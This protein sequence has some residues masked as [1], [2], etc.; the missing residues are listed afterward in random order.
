MNGRWLDALEQYISSC[1]N[2]LLS[3]VYDGF[4]LTKDITICSTLEHASDII[5]GYHESRTWSDPAPVMYV[6]TPAIEAH[7]NSMSGGVPIADFTA[8]N[9]PS[10]YKIGRAHV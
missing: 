2:D 5:H 9:L 7:R 1:E 10:K 6:R 8:L 4:L 3:L